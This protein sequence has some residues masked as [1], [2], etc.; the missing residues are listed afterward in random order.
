MIQIDL[1]EK[2]ESADNPVLSLDALEAREL[3]DLLRKL[4]QKREKDAIEHLTK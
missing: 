3:F 4:R 2:I 1:L